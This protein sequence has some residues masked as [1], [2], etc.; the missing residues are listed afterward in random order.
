[1][2][3]KK[4]GITLLVIAIFLLGFVFY[5]NISNILKPLEN[6]LVGEGLGQLCSHEE[7]CIDFC[8][9]NRG[10]CEIYC[11]ENSSN[12]LCGKLFLNSGN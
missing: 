6:P 11:R 5:V 7:D 8:H 12:E 2:E 4:L 1:M 9:N 10:Q 3:D